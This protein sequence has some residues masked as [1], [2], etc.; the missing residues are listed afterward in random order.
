VFVECTLERW[1]GS[2]QVIAAFPTGVTDLAL[3]FEQE[4]INGKHAEWIKTCDPILR[5]ARVFVESGTATRDE[6]F[7][8]DSRVSE[9]MEDARA[10][11][12]AS[13][14]PEPSAAFS[15]VFA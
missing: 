9:L 11:A 6:L 15:G 2:H 1:P 13:P 8:M 12:E 4:K 7:A 3:A 14:F 10:F 5:A